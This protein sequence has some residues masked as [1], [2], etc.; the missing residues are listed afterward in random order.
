MADHLSCTQKGPGSIPGGGTLL[1]HASVVVCLAQT[2]IAQ[3]E[4]TACCFRFSLG[5]RSAA[6]VMDCSET[7]H[8]GS[9]C[10]VIPTLRGT[11][12]NTRVCMYVRVDVGCFVRPNVH[13]RIA[14][15]KVTFI[16]LAVGQR[17]SVDLG[18]RSKA[19]VTGFVSSS[20]TRSETKSRASL[21]R[22]VDY[23]REKGV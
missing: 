14:T 7:D 21:H 1:P 19:S 4:C 16:V 5:R 8:D 23:R 13:S 3:L 6:A 2:E 9:S 10:V 12:M 20:T 17:Q 18:V 22:A 15:R 11:S